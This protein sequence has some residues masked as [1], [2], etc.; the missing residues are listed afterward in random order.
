MNPRAVLNV[1]EEEEKSVDPA[2]IRMQVV[3]TIACQ[4]TDCST[5]V[6]KALKK[7]INFFLSIQITFT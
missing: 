7:L 3:Q 5:H 2:G 6:L 4:R 1:L